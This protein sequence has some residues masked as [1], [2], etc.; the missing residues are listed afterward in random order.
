MSTPIIQASWVHGLG[1]FLEDKSWSCD[2]AGWGNKVY[3]SNTSLQGWV[4]FAIPTPVIV[5]DRRLTPTQVGLRV[6][7]GPK[8]TI[9]NIGVHDGEKG[10]AG[11]NVNLS[12][13][14][15]PQTYY[16]QIPSP[17]EILWGTEI[18]VLV[19]F[20]DRSSDAWVDFVSAGIDFH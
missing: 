17:P 2:R 10:I 11:F 6:A 8:A 20:G 19:N 13:V 4:H 18:S 16:Y 14:A 7:I 9:A 15:N 12:N 1:L 5:D 3:P